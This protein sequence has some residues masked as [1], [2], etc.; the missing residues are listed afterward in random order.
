MS[1]AELERRISSSELT[2]WIAYADIEPFG[3][4]MDNYRMGVPASMIINAIRST[5]PLPKG[6]SRPKA[7]QPNDLYPTKSNAKPALTEEQREHI[8]KKQAKRAKK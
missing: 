6:K 3:Y 4:P 1:V 8:R 2:R 7:L 5:I